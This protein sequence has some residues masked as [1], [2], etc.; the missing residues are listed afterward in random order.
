MHLPDSVLPEVVWKK[1]SGELYMDS[2]IVRY[3]IDSWLAGFGNS[4]Y[5]HGLIK[6]PGIMRLFECPPGILP[7]YQ[8]SHSFMTE[9][10]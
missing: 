4:L 8:I 6:L 3:W 2:R 9:A 1:N 10:V 5:Q 7:V